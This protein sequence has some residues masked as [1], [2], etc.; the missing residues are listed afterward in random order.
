MLKKL[1]IFLALAAIL[2]QI[3]FAS[4]PFDTPQ[5]FPPPV[6]I[7][8]KFNRF[9]LQN[10]MVYAKS[11]LYDA[12][13]DKLTLD[14]GPSGGFSKTIHV[15]NKN[16]LSSDFEEG[17]TPED[18]TF[19]LTG[20]YNKG[21]I[22]SEWTYNLHIPPR[23]GWKFSDDYTGSGTFYSYQ[24]ISDISGIGIIEGSVTR[25]NTNWKDDKMV[26][27]VQETKTDTFRN[28]WMAIGSCT[29]PICGCFEYDDP[30]DSQARFNSLTNEV[31]YAHCYKGEKTQEWI[32]ATPKV[33]LMVND[34]VSTGA[35]SSAIL[36]FKD[37]TTFKMKPETEVIVKS[38]PAQETKLGLVAGHLWINFKK[39]L[40]NG[41]MEVEMGQAVAGI[42]G[43]TLVL[44]QVNGVSS[45]KVI[46]GVVSFKS[47][48]TG[49][50]V[51]V[52][53]GETIS[54]D[55]K[56]LSKV[57]T[58]DVT[59]ETADWDTLAETKKTKSMSGL[60]FPIIGVVAVLVIGL[61][62]FIVYKKRKKS[63][64]TKI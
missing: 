25:N 45:L 24:P 27:H 42:K 3:V 47:K 36:Q 48:E 1:T 62:G 59:K 38:P 40:T 7:N 28:S 11:G 14:I 46:E 33:K 64:L 20:T 35:E 44:D 23:K 10:F 41:T 50:S 9:D 21:N 2:P 32:P 34:H 43:T 49:E 63:N 6:K 26:D 12:I 29:E 16:F 54:A 51:D 19:T 13:S 15:D 37:M 57:E 60:T 61:F 30:V 8:V 39:M 5:F 17:N 18:G 31:G 53:E 52:K 4:P 56:G 22:S 55:L 58:F